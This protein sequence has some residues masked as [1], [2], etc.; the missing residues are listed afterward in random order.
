MVAILSEQALPS[1]PEDPIFTTVFPETLPPMQAYRYFPPETT[2][3]QR[4]GKKT[5]RNFYGGG[6]EFDYFEMG[7]ID[8]FKKYIRQKK[9]DSIPLSFPKEE[10]LKHLYAAD[11]NMKTATRLINEHQQFE[12][13]QLPC[14]LT[15]A[16][17]KLLVSC[18]T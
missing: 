3:K 12:A 11:F 15:P 7:M 18:A 10:M 4:Y 13:E 2:V 14:Q 1:D 5:V 8:D 6:L 16:T 17:I 9:I